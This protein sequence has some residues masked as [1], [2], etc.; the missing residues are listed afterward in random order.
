MMNKVK[1]IRTR[2]NE[3]I[4]FSDL[5]QH[6]DF[7]HFDPVSAGFISIG[8]TKVDGYPEVTCS[9]YGESVSLEL[10]SDEEK[11][12][13]LAKRQILGIPY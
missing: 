10:K 8:I 7:K 6:K 5:Q 1:Y 3:I 9:C 13:R 12:T 4:V 2:N 11:D